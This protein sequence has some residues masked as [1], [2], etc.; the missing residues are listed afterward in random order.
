[1]TESLICDQC[2]SPV[3]PAVL[4][5]HCPEC[6]V[7]HSLDFSRVVAIADSPVADRLN[8]SALRVPTPQRVGD[9]ELVGEIARGGM[10]VVYR[11]RQI[12]L[13]RPVALK[14]LLSG[15]FADADQIERFR[16]EAR[17]VALLDH[18]GIVPIYEIGEFEGRNFF[19]M[20][21]VEGRSLAGMMSEF[22]LASTRRRA[23]REGHSVGPA[24]LA[25]QR[26]L[27]LALAK[28][29]R[30]VHYAHQRGVL[31]R[32]LKPANI[33]ID[34]D[35][36]PLVTDFG[37]ARLM[38]EERRLTKPDA[39][40][41]TPSYMP[42]EQTVA[43]QMVTIAA[44]VY[45]IGAI[46]YELMT[47][48]PPF[49]A[50]NAVET[51]IQ[52]REKD[53]TPP[54]LLEPLIE[55]DLETILLKCLSK[56]PSARYE[57]ALALAEDL[58]RFT[59]NEPVQA[60]PVRVVERAWLWARRH[61]TIAVL[62]TAITVLVIGVAVVAPLVALQLAHDR[63]R[64][65][66]ARQQAQ[67][68][69]RRANLAR[70]QAERSSAEAGLRDRGL[71]AVAEA[72]RIRPDEES[73]AEGIAQLARLD[74]R[75]DP[76]LRP[77]G[78]PNQPIVVS[79][80]LS[81]VYL[82]TTNATVQARAIADNA[83][84]WQRSDADFGS[85]SDLQIT[86][87]GEFLGI[88]HRGQVEIIRTSNQK[89]VCRQSLVEFLRFSPDGSWFLMISSENRV[90]RRETTTGRLLGTLPLSAI[91]GGDVAISGDPEK[92]WVA[93]ITGRSLDIL[94]WESGQKL[95]SLDQPE[96]CGDLAWSGEW[97]AA[98]ARSGRILVWHLPTGKIHSIHGH[99]TELRSLEFIP[100]TRVIISAG[101]DGLIYAWDVA[102]GDRLLTSS[103]SSPIHP[104]P[105]GGRLVFGTPTTWN[106]TDVL[107]PRGRSLI[108]CRDRG[109][110]AIRS[111]DFSP[112][113]RWLLVTKQAGVHVV[114]LQSGSK[115]YFLPADPALQA[116]FI[117]GTNQVL[118]Q[119][120]TA[121]LWFEFDPA[122]GYLGASP[123]RS[124]RPPTISTV[125]WMEPATFAAN[126]P[127]VY[128]HLLDGTEEQIGLQDGVVESRSLH[129]PLAQALQVARSGP[130][131]VYCPPRG[132]NFRHLNLVDGESAGVLRETAGLPLF[133]PDGNFL[134]LS[135]VMGHDLVSVGD[136][137]IMRSQPV[138]GR[139]SGSP[140]PAAWT[141]DSRSVAL[142]VDRN[143]ITL[144][145]ARD[146]SVKATLT[147][148]QP[149]AYTHLRFSPG[150][151]WLAAGTDHGSVELW[152][153]LVLQQDLEKLGL[154]LDWSISDLEWEKPA[155]ASSYPTGS[156]P[157]PANLPMPHRGIAPRQAGAGSSQ[158][159]L[160]PFY[161]SA[162]A[163]DP[164][165]PSSLADH[166]QSMPLGM[167]ESD[168]VQ[169]EIRG[170]IQLSGERRQREVG[171]LPD[172]VNGIPVRQSFKRLHLLGAVSNAPRYLLRPQ[173]VARV[174][175]HYRDGEV[176]ETPL[177]LGEELEDYWSP[178]RGPKIARKATVGWQ[179]FSP[180]SESNSNM[181][182]L[183]HAVLNN[184][185][186][187]VDVDSI[188]LESAKAYPDPFFVAATVD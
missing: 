173:V 49:E 122:H 47:G 26:E 51:L 104:N 144:Q 50:G 110:D 44:D 45:S 34:V 39:V 19:S 130:H 81:T 10:G 98:G 86:G 145:E 177:T 29:A 46:G 65:E 126:Q 121:V 52:L 92:P 82:A 78:G 115:V 12:S 37:L 158:L 128:L 64:A 53:P 166:F 28:I 43:P 42:P 97:L 142:V 118:V 164:D 150:N 66:E 132:G 105:N 102:S 48:Q 125:A 188:D 163:V 171:T 141:R 109:Y 69:L 85:I 181:I 33:L 178:V 24:V 36:N 120:R 68:D 9:Y 156:I 84:L 135:G 154:Q 180:S 185:R 32:D 131:A 165:D 146:G 176:R 11:A 153:L 73:S 151:R 182:Q 117:P 16:T 57:S 93:A 20:K 63:E 149:N 95:A 89:T 119:T 174:R 167:L 80:D 79:P 179:S 111:I 54:R 6:M 3:H 133:S 76:L 114:D 87:D 184:P 106:W 91:G 169:F 140:P 155:T 38:G 60:R 5:G 96:L 55:R 147:T 103:G 71:A 75:S 134:V 77:R 139:L 100:G 186:P 137:K 123:L 159:D 62:S 138:L 162:L 59:R 70:A 148:P 129:P 94:N 74:L 127:Y 124:H 152:D 56:E 13:N 25:R 187:D 27:A 88:F 61:P 72:A 14:V 99:R 2:G 8:V 101:M 168:G 113:S 172:R 107:S 15:Q 41:G 161:N 18:P 170:M 160:G 21:L 116:Q 143:R 90:Q 30:A 22:D 175:F 4:S 17:A 40:V 83:L 31:H 112:D 23:L 58:E 35:G 136:W 1:M 67:R 183:L 108:N 7:R 157:D